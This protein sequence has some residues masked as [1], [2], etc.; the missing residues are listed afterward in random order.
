M[1]ESM[2]IL[3]RSN[4]HQTQRANPDH[5]ACGFIGK[6]LLLA[7]VLGAFVGTGIFLVDHSSATS[8]MSSDPKACTNCHI[9]RDEFNNWQHS[10]HHAAAVCNDCHVPQDAVGKYTMK[11][12]HGYRHSKGFTLGDFH[13]PIM[14]K[15]DSLAVVEA[16]CI[17]CHYELTSE[18][19]NVG[20]AHNAVG[21][22]AFGCT[23]CHSH[24]GHGPSK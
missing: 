20:V 10:S 6:G 22:G 12:V 21:D 4:D 11:A 17:R 3:G 14:I 23:H 1:R 15:P 8:Y 13:E 16:N 19:S 18:V 9:M 2:A 7:I 24:V 5:A